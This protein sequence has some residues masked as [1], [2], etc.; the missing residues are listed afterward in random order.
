MQRSLLRAR[1]R[2]CPERASHSGSRVSTGGAGDHTTAGSSA[3][4]CYV[5]GM[6]AG[7]NTADYDA[8]L[9]GLDANERAMLEETKRQGKASAS[10]LRHVT[11]SPKTGRPLEY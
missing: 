5:R 9:E 1:S 6:D 11:K 10:R 4:P 3:P 2:S 7:M 8:R